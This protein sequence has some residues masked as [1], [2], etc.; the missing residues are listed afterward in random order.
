MRKLVFGSIWV[1]L[2]AGTACTNSPGS[3]SV[4]FSS[5]LAAGPSSGSSYRFK[6]QP[7]TLSITNVAR[8][9]PAP[10]TYS[11]EVASDPAFTTK[12]FTKDSIPE[13]GNGTT[14]VTLPALIAN[15]G[16][17]TFYWRW[18]ASVDGVASALS[19]PQ[20]FTVQQ[21]IILGAPTPSTPASGITTTSQ[22]PTFVANNAPRQG[23][24]GPIS[25]L[26]QVSTSSG[27]GAILASATVAEG[28][29][30]A[31]GT[32]SWTPG[33]DLPGGTIFWRIQ[34]SDPA[35][36]ET[37]GFS[38][39]NSFVVQPFSLKD[40]EI[41]N[42][43]PDLADWAETTKIT[44]ID[45]STGFMMVDFDQRLT[46]RWP[47]SGFGVEYTLGAC[48]NISARWRCSAVIQFWTG[49]D[50]EASGPAGEIAQ[51][52]YYGRWGIMNGYQPAIGEVIGVFVAQ[53]NL[54]DNAHETVVFERSNV[55]FT[56]FGTNYSLSTATSSSVA[57]RPFSLI[58][59]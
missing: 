14:S 3:P 40:A 59:R 55:A 49:R 5:P 2:A 56:P 11:V 6:E 52:W 33:V 28:S 20:T 16:N 47:E 48:F 23:A 7:V 19:P 9:G 43:P 44:S 25:Y 13:G 36:A 4:S 42:N 27:F 12:V 39:V 37:G 34:A 53:G 32:T 1:A 41:I 22:R 57:R 54:R 15:S 51:N 38:T 45:F 10:T 30:G 18:K 31:G 58:K 35:N 46:G 29:G 21:Q 26:F 50:L 17:V 24:V 8:T